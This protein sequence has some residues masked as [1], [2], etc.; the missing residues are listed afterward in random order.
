VSV[1]WAQLIAYH[2]LFLRVIGGMSGVEETSICRKKEHSTLSLFSLQEFSLSSLSLHLLRVYFLL[3]FPLGRCLFFS[4]RC[5]MVQNQN[6]D[7]RFC[8]EEKVNKDEKHMSKN[9]YSLCLFFS[10]I[11]P[12]THATRT[13]SFTKS[14][15]V[16]MP[17]TKILLQFCL[18]L[19]DY[20]A[21]P[22]WVG[23]GFYEGVGTGSGCV[24]CVCV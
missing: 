12:V 1:C 21:F 20:Q 18:A 3:C 10:I 14:C 2:C 9:M 17:R 4:A 8:E 7:R 23:V 11:N 6:Q 19:R 5:C 24:L 15:P 13:Q 22:G 16:S